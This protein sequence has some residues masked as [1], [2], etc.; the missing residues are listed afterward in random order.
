MPIASDQD[1]QI[2]YVALSHCQ[3]ISI[4]QHVQ[5]SVSIA[6]NIMNIM[7]IINIIHSLLMKNNHH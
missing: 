5:L 1:I 7:N 6:I 2:L 4:Y 3:V